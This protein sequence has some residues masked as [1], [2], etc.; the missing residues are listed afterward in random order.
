MSLRTD[1]RKDVVAVLTTA[2][3][4][5]TVLDSSVEVVDSA[6]LPAVVV[7]GTDESVERDEGFM[8]EPSP[9]YLRQLTIRCEYYEAGIDGMGVMDTLED[10]LETSEAALYADSG[11][12]V[13]VR[14][15]YL[16]SVEVSMNADAGETRGLLAAN[17]TA[18][19]ERLG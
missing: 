12:D 6:L 13:L 4:G 3:S 1:I 14:D 15:F 11:L 16:T 2:L 10:M 9:T 8:G 5:N 7:Y 17:F 18:E 19:Y